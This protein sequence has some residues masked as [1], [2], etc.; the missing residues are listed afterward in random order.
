MPPSN[1]SATYFESYLFL[2]QGHVELN[3]DGSIFPTYVTSGRTFGDR[4]QDAAIY[5]ARL[6]GHKQL[7]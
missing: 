4:F 2:G 1:L 7:I 3:M 5:E 6:R